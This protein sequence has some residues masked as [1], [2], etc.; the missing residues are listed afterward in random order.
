VRRRPAGSI[1]LPAKPWDDQQLDVSRVQQVIISGALL[2]TYFMALATSLSDVAAESIITSI[3]NNRM[4]FSNMPGV[5][6]T[7][8]GLLRISQ[9]SYLAFKAN[10]RE[11]ASATKDAPNP[12]P[13]VRS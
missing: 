5:G 2:S 8:L 10:A 1:S 7:F 9:A 13:A 3:T 11:G 4:V 12:N 6:A